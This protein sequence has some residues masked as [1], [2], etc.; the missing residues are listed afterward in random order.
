MFSLISRT[1]YGK[2]AP[3]AIKIVAMTNENAAKGE[4]PAGT[5]SVDDV[6][7][8]HFD[9]A[10]SAQSSLTRTLRDDRLCS[11]T[12]PWFVS[13]IITILF[14]VPTLWL[15]VWFLRDLIGKM[16]LA[17]PFCIHATIAVWCTRCLIPAESLR[18]KRPSFLFRAIPSVLDIWLLGSFYS[19]IWYGLEMYLFTDVDG[20]A[21]REYRGTI[22][23]LSALRFYGLGIAIL[24]AFVDGV[25]L[26]FLFYTERLGCR[27]PRFA[28]ILVDR[29]ES[30]GTASIST[31]QRR[32]IRLGLRKI[33]LVILVIASLLL[34]WSIDSALVGWIT[35]S[36]PRH[37]GP[38]CDP[39]DDTEC[40]F[41][42][43]S[44]FHLK[45]DD[46]TTTGF[47]VDIRADSM[48]RLKGGGKPDPSFL[49]EL[50]GF[51]TMSPI[52][53]YVDGMK[54]A[55]ESG[56]SKLCGHEDLDKS[57]TDQSVTLLF[58]VENGSLVAHSAEI[59]YLD[60]DR[61]S[62][63]L[64]PAQPLKHN[65]RYGVAL[66]GATGVD[67][68][69]VLRRTEGMD[70]LLDETNQSE[71]SVAARETLVPS[72]EKAAP[73]IDGADTR[74]QL[75][76]DFHT[77]S[78]ESQLG[79]S[80][81]IRDQTIK[82]IKGWDDW[83][84]H[85]R[86]IKV[87][88]FTCSSPNKDKNDV[89]AHT[90]TEG[91]LITRTVHA[92]IDVPWFLEDMHRRHAALDDRLFT[93]GYVP[94]INT[95]KFI[96]HVPCSL[97]EAALGRSNTKLRGVMDYGHSL[98]Y[99]RREAAD[100]AYAKLADENGYII[101]ATDWR[102]MSSSDLF[103]V[104]KVLISKP[105]MFRVI[106]DNL[107][108]GFAN[109]L[110]LQYFV[111]HGGLLEMP[112]FRFNDQDIDA[113]GSNDKTSSIDHS[114]G[115]NAIPLSDDTTNSA[116]TA[117]FYGVSQGGIL[118]AGYTTLAGP[119]GLIDRVILGVPGAS[120]TFI[121][122]R[123]FDFKV[124]DTALLFNF[125]HNRHARLFLSMAQVGFDPTEAAGQLAPP[126]TEPHPP[127]LLQAGLGDQV[128]TTYSAEALTRAYGGIILEDSPRTDIYGIPV[129]PQSRHSVIAAD[130]TLTELLF[131]KEYAGL[132][133][134][135]D[136][137]NEKTKVHLCVR[138]D[139]AMLKQIAEFVNTGQVLNVCMDDG[140]ERDHASCY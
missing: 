11:L 44:S 21:V 43:P 12:E 54:E 63:L 110:T 132:S 134:T 130:V 18:S 31:E 55:F 7:V 102:G 135:N 97:K 111:K 87:E 65:T 95:A 120:W 32:S 67:D 51:S 2:P 40:A 30:V 3:A 117:F 38:S 25:A 72:L 70:R 22:V 122:S 114:V 137:P 23:L 68:T 13:C 77:M 47:K 49:N 20:T 27:L 45:R 82:T 16:W 89:G 19:K 85:V 58:D 50:D 131:R 81:A 78:A 24:R 90:A 59:D 83:N 62:V 35:W 34:V 36:P 125:Y 26:L 129:H 121:M 37:E 116:P 119:T 48:P 46:S 76:F 127:V 64:I 112:C 8:Y 96:V 113:M 126:L 140:C 118:G 10:P 53:F 57:I 14:I 69:T 17:L 75:L 91:S 41:P 104:A 101:V 1:T 60:P 133:P 29:I 79:P 4:D 92:E 86:I 88:D 139:P 123:S 6:L 138:Q 33:L 52:L 100:E 108:Q 74:L 136:I 107:L 39:L 56:A 80:R 124:Y 128:V 105:G 42:F 98:L 61:P 5:Y 73:W 84:D 94:P 109:K 28:A 99:N 93:E 115:S 9:G 106:R 66:Y 103:V 15:A 71:R